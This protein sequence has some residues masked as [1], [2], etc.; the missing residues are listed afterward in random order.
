MPNHIS[1]ELKEKLIKFY[2]NDGDYLK[3]AQQ[4]DIKEKTARTII[5]R[6]RKKLHQGH[7]GGYKSKKNVQMGEMLLFFVSE[8]PTVT[9]NEMRQYMLDSNPGLQISRNCIT[10]FLDGKLITYKKTR[11]VPVQRNS[12]RV[13]A[14]RKNYA[15]WYLEDGSLNSELIYVEEVGVNIW[16]KRKYEHSKAGERCFQVVGGIRG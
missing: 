13:K 6:K 16:T 15:R 11:D 10:T 1:K 4:L 7:I 14:L 8:N 9:I 12:D 3:L 2:E 5:Y